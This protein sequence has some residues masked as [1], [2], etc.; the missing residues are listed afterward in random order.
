MFHKYDPCYGNFSVRIVDGSLSRVAGT[1]SIVISKDLILE[2]VLFVPNSDCN[3]LS[4]SKI[5]R[6]LNFVTK[7]SPNM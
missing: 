4:I 6:D 1:G 2:S 7:F 5:T 3:L